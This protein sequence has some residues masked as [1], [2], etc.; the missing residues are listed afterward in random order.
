MSTLRKSML[1]FQAR[2]GLLPEVYTAG[3]DGGSLHKFRS[4]RDYENLVR[5][6][7]FQHKKR[8]SSSER[9]GLGPPTDDAKEPRALAFESL[10][11]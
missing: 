2:T 7:L 6:R 11:I 1:T 5:S 3:S 9:Q 10:S 8:V 4:V